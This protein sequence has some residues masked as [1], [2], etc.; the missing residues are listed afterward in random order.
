MSILAAERSERDK[1]QVFG[2]TFC[3]HGDKMETYSD[4]LD[5]TAQWL[6]PVHCGPCTR[7]CRYYVSMYVYFDYFC[8]CFSEILVRCYRIPFYKCSVIF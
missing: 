4:V 1:K 2:A 3:C 6:L 7:W 5:L 8:G